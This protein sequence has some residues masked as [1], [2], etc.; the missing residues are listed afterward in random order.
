MHG[1]G[2]RVGLADSRLWQTTALNTS[3]G[4]IWANFAGVQRLTVRAWSGNR[5]RARD[6]CAAQR[7]KLVH[8]PRRDRSAPQKFFSGA[9]H[10]SPRI[11]GSGCT[12]DRGR[13]LVFARDRVMGKK[14]Y[15]G[16]L[17]WSFTSQELSDLFAAYG[18]VASA[19]VI[20][21]RE[22]GRSRGFGFVEMETEEAAKA[23]AAALNET[24][25]RGRNL[26]VNEARERTPQ[27]RGG[28]G[29][30]GGGGGGYGGGG[31]RRGGGGGGYGGGGGGYRGGGDRGGDGG[32]R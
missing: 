8:E 17:A 11:L 1:L 12:W 26:T 3:R 15:V 2:T 10:T 7:A 19:E 24:D 27:G 16:N 31:G 14:L 6:I 20:I 13:C 4:T 22:T 25:C 18:K 9:S 23:A 32:Y 21:D 28:G 5:H 30:G 29:Y